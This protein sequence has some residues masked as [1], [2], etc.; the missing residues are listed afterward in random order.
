MA[1]NYV[2]S[3]M[4]GLYFEIREDS[5]ADEYSVHFF[6]IIKNETIHQEVI[7]QGYHIRLFDKYF[8]HIRITVYDSKLRKVIELTTFDLIREKRF[9]IWFDSNSIGDTIAWMGMVAEFAEKHL[10][11]EVI[12][13][14]YHNY[15]FEKAYPNLTFAAPAEI[16]PNL[17][18]QTIL[19]IYYDKEHH[20]RHPMTV[21][22]HQVASDMLALEPLE[23]RRPELDFIPDKRYIKEPYYA[24]GTQSTSDLK[25][26]AIENW[27]EV[28]DS[29]KP[30]RVVDLS[31]QP[32][33]LNGTIG[34]YNK[35]MRSVMQYLHHAEFFI[36]LSSG[37]SWLAW[38]MGKK[39]YM[40]ANFT[41]DWYEF[42]CTRFTDTSVCHGCFNNPMYKFDKSRTFCPFHVGTELEYICQKSIKPDIVIQAIQND[43]SNKKAP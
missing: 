33:E 34:I 11:T 10:T 16:V 30:L 21:P 23:P 42:E 28:I 1:F 24:I 8:K 37:L 36:G 17:W 2:T 12:V 4:N 40:I 15:L 9:F 20:P 32:R 5:D 7:K 18:G 27:Q 22:L 14:T 43:L 38:A 35:S 19:A 6:D 25:E 31:L 29:L 13:C 41:K 3:Y 39:V 26:W